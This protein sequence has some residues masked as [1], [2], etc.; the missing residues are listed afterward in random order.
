MPSLD[1][2][3]ILANYF[4][5]PIDYIVYG[6]KCMYSDSHTKKDELTRLMYLLDSLVL[7]PVKE[8]N[9]DSSYFG[10]YLFLAFD[11]DVTLLMDK[12]EA[13]ANETNIAFYKGEGNKT[14]GLEDYLKLINEISDLDEDWSVSEK[15]FRAQLI[16][17]NIDPNEYFYNSVTKVMNERKAYSLMEKKKK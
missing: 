11:N 15:R 10:K 6:K 17:S 7:T 14:A 2:I 8:K 13:L 12:R 3:A 4:D 9:P 16:R 1:K 5:C